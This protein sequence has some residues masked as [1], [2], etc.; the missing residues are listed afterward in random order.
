[1]RRRLLRYR[2]SFNPYQQE[3][4]ITVAV[5]SSQQTTPCLRRP[6]TGDCPGCGE[7]F[8]NT[9]TNFTVTKS[10]PKAFIM[11]PISFG[12][13]VAGII[14]FGVGMFAM[15]GI[16]CWYKRQIALHWNTGE[17]TTLIK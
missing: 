17:Q 5:D 14:F 7:Y 15:I 11:S 4:S 13:M 8:C 10:A 1:M 2:Y 12:V 16:H 6:T 3:G 9:G